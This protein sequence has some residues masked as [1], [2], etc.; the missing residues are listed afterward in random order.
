MYVPFQFLE[1]EFLNHFHR[2][3]E[4]VEAREGFSKQEK[5]RMFMSKQSYEGVQ[6]TGTNHVSY[7][8]LHIS[9]RPNPWNSMYL[10]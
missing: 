5:S 9:I 2:W 4:A 1:D 6:V 10:L 8:R 3:R 7:N